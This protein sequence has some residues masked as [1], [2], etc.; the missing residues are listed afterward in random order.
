MTRFGRKHG[1]VSEIMAPTL[2]VS[3]FCDIEFGFVLQK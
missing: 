3:A 2:T 1:L